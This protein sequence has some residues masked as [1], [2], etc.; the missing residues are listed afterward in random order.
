MAKA[1]P[2]ALYRHV[3]S[4]FNKESVLSTQPNTARQY[5]EG[6]TLAMAHN[7]ASARP[8]LSTLALNY[9]CNSKCSYCFIWKNQSENTPLED[10]KRAIDQ[11]AEL[12]VAGISLTGGEPFLHPD[13]AEIVAHVRQTGRICSITTNGLLLRPALLRALGEAGLNSL[14]I[15]LDTIDPELYERIRGVPLSKVLRGLAYALD[16]RERRPDLAVAINCV[17]S[18]TNFDHIPELVEFCQQR[19]IS[20]GFQPLHPAF[21]S[22]WREAPDLIFLSEDRTAL[23][24]LLAHVSTMKANGY[25]INSPAAYLDGFLSYLIERKLP[26]GFRCNAGFLTIAVDYKLNVRSC[27]SLPPVGNVLTDD[28]VGLWESAAY[29]ERRGRMMALDCPGCWLRCHTEQR[30]SEWIDA[31]FQAASR[32]EIG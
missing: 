29:Q 26:A 28:L 14:V 22:G 19:N 12:G 6:L 13:L 9:R 32:A 24:N 21:A 18:R 30:S 10:L 2:A 5:E 23:A 7:D 31:L 20:I 15:S 25:R 4:Q 16:E 8:I 3:L 1:I 27:W 17:V 11:L